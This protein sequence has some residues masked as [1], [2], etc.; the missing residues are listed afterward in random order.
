ML[1]IVARTNFMSWRLAPSAA[2]PIGPP[3]PSVN[4]L[5]LTPDLARSV[6][7]GPLFSPA[8]RGFGHRPVHT[9]P[10]PVNALQLVKAIHP[11]LPEFQKHPGC[12]PLL[13]AIVGGGTG[14][15]VS[16]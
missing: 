5:R 15:Q 10:F 12:N 3:C 2:R 6:G 9:H 14:A 11:H 7:L 13:I 4:R 8:Q 16:L 1:S